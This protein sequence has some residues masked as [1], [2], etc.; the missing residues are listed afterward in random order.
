M[1]LTQKDIKEIIEHYENGA[2]STT[3]GKNYNVSEASIRYH[4]EKNGVQIRTMTKE[5]LLLKKFGLLTV[6]APL[7][8]LNGDTMWLCRCDCK[9]EVPVRAY[10]LKSGHTGSCG[11]IKYESKYKHPKFASAMRVWRANYKD[12]DISFEDFLIESQKDCFY[13]GKSASNS[14]RYNTA[15]HDKNASKFAKEEGYFT[16]NGLDRLDSDKKH[17]K[18]NCVP[19]CWECNVCKGQLHIDD[20]LKKVETIYN[21]VVKKNPFSFNVSD[22]VIKNTE[23]NFV[24]RF[25]L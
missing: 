1:K 21:R 7:P 11:C 15:E 5:D 12:G 8:K 10:H 13:C 17:I 2:G 25:I 23:T 20:F 16:Y 19:C 22:D 6:I 4:L 18:N 14:N 24:N 9:K 3:L